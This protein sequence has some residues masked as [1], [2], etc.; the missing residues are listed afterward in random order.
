MGRHVQEW[1]SSTPWTT[2]IGADPDDPSIIYYFGGWQGLIKA[3]LDFANG[4]FTI[5]NTYNLKPAMDAMGD[6]S[7]Y[8]NEGRVFYDGFRIRKRSGVTYLVSEH[9]EV[10]LG[11]VRIDPVTQEAI[12]CTH[13]DMD[14]QRRAVGTA[15]VDE[16][17][18]GQR[19]ESEITR[20]PLNWYLNNIHSGPNF[21]FYGYNSSGDDFLQKIKVIGWTAAGCPIYEPMSVAAQSAWSSQLMLQGPHYLNQIWLSPSA[22]GTVWA[23]VNEKQVG[24]NNAKGTRVM[25]FDAT[26]QLMVRSQN[27]RLPHPG[28]YDKPD[29]DNTPIC[30]D[31]SGDAPAPAGKTYVFRGI[32]GTAFGNFIVNDYDGG[33]DGA[34]VSWNY[35][36]NED[37]LWVG[38]LFENPDLAKAP[39]ESYSLASDN[40]SGHVYA[41]AASGNVYVYGAWDSDFKVF[42]VTGWRDFV[43]ASG[44]VIAP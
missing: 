15:W 34:H 13:L 27:L 18:D 4:R 29:G 35:V 39:R 22:D 23:A 38:Q 32:M 7:P 2:Y 33:W 28:A 41:D 8:D 17:G 19:Q 24:W 10:S 20:V 42:K 26:G 40:R 1:M 6:N 21:D 9:R 30:C 43:R 16:N 31:H 14:L 36:W 3:K 44:Q 37:G 5:L 11:V 25:R 12:A